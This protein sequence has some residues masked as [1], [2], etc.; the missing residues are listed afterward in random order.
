M[1]GIDYVTIALVRV[2]RGAVLAVRHDRTT[3][4]YTATLSRRR[5]QLSSG[6]GDTAL[7]AQMAC[8][9]YLIPDMLPD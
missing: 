5:K 9:R 7:D 3:G 4:R 1:M 8:V 6:I 2:G